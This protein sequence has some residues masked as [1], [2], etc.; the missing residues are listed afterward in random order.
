MGRINGKNR[1]RI[2][3]NGLF[4]GWQPLALLSDNFC[5][6]VRSIG[7]GYGNAKSRYLTAP[8]RACQPTAHI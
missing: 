2:D 3:D 4:R 7:T 5:G 6:R 8:D 1:G